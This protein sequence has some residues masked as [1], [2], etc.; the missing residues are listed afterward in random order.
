MPYAPAT[1]P[2]HP[3]WYSLC[4]EYGIYLIDEGNIETHGFGKTFNNLLSN[5]P[6]WTQSIY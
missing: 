4:D 5:D 1:I 3:E 6:A 2:M